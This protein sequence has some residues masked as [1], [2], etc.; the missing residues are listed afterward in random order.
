MKIKFLG[1]AGTVTGSCHVVET[2]T[3]IFAVDCGMFQGLKE[4]KEKNYQDFQVDPKSI[5]FL[6]LTHAHIDHSGLIPKLC[7]LGFKGPIYCNKATAELCKVMLPDS[8]YIQ[9][10][11]IERK[12]RKLL[13]AGQ[14]PIEP[15]YTVEDAM[16]CLEQL[17]PVN[18][19]QTIELAPG[20]KACFR[21]AGH[22][23]GSSIVEVWLEEAGKQCKVVFSGDLGQENQPIIND[24]SIIDSAD[25]VL[26]ESTY[27]DR[28]HKD[29]L[30]RLEKLKQVIDE[31]MKK[32]GNLIIPA[33]AVERTQ[34]LLYD[35]NQLYVRGDLDPKINI[36]IDSPL[37]IAA[38]EIFKNN[39]Q[40][41]DN[42]TLEFIRNGSNPFKMPN[43]KYSRSQEESMELNKI[44]GG[45]II[46]SASGMCEAG[47]IKYHLKYNLWRAEST[48]LFV[49]YQA[50][51]T[52][53]RNILE[54][55]KLVTIHGEEVNVKADIRNIEAY[56]A[57]ADQ[58][59][60]ISWLKK[61][62][63]PPKQVILVHGEEKAQ[64]VL[65][66]L[67][68]K[69]LKLP[70]YIPKWLDEMELL[71]GDE[72]PAAPVAVAPVPVK[73]PPTAPVNDALQ[74]EEMYLLIRSRLNQ[75]FQESTSAEDYAA[76]IDVLKNIEKML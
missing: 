44:E 25:Y 26:I 64:Q 54:G 58:A 33:F 49:G 42:E 29:V 14:M 28:F 34:D 47:R 74:A 68:Q 27:G 4:I 16:N 75:M 11:E 40:F 37:A 8:A 61:F 23:L 18:Y 22:I 20:V 62:K 67:I 12:N 35:L 36:Y 31:T 53:G 6:I 10:S 2:Q 39:S 52:L 60:L 38:T 45:A 48:I 17:T 76:F 70:V 73:L 63:T 5:D 69:G 9:E 55:E 51:G 50:V 72:I 59:G 19:D 15:I 56:S 24:P 32:G 41:Y 7:R 57:H 46:I 13:R 1:A 65:G 21:D 43:L 30:N 71:P 66:E 3:S